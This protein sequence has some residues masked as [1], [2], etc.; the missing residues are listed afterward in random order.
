MGF[1]GTSAAGV[2]CNGVDVPIAANDA[3]L[4]GPEVWSSIA[5]D[6]LVL[7]REEK[8]V[9]E[10]RPG[11]GEAS[12]REEMS[13]REDVSVREEFTR[14]LLTLSPPLHEFSTISSTI[15]STMLNVV[16]SLDSMP[17]QIQC[18][19]KHSQP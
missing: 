5:D 3:C 9:L 11:R 10:E 4:S 6:E 18:S 17:G 12:V 2:S 7:D 19:E 15:D 13:V 1:A 8:S 16:R 14:S